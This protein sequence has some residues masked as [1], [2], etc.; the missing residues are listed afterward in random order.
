LP[1]SSESLLK[2]TDTGSSRALKAAKG[3]HRNESNERSSKPLGSLKRTR[4]PHDLRKVLGWRGLPQFPVSPLTSEA[5]EDALQ[6]LL[7]LRRRQD[8]GQDFLPQRERSLQRR[9]R[10]RGESRRTNAVDHEVARTW[11][12]DL[13]RPSG[14]DGDDVAGHYRLSLQITDPRDA[15]PSIT[16]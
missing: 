16:M 5:K 8:L 10:L 6:R 13:L 11:V 2:L 9:V 14:R 3:S 12:R 15:F 1:P 7:L 4:C